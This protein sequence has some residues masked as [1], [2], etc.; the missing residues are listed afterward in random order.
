MEPCMDK[1][2]DL[3]SLLACIEHYLARGSARAGVSAI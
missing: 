3:S 1:P 2:F